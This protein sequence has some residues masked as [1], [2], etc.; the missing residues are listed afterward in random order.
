MESHR[1]DKKLEQPESW[2]GLKGGT[3]GKLE[4]LKITG[5][6]AAPVEHCRLKQ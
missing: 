3:T 5:I 6:F 4:R 1:D 2:N